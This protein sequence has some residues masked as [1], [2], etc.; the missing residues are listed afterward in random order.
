MRKAAPKDFAQTD[1]PI[2]KD[3]LNVQEYIDVLSNFITSCETPMTLAIQGDWGSGKTSMMNMVEKALP[4]QSCTIVRFNTWQYSQF[5]MGDD[6][7]LALMEHLLHAVSQG[8]D[9]D[10]FSVRNRRAHILAGLR[11]LTLGVAGAA[12]QMA[13]QSVPFGEPLVQVAQQGF[14]ATKKAQREAEQRA[15]P[16]FRGKTAVIEGLKDELQTYVTSALDAL[17]V[18]TGNGDQPPK[19]LVVMIDDLDRLPPERAVEVMEALKIFLDLERCV[20]VLAIDFDVVKQGVRRKFGQ[21]FTERKAIAFF[22]K[23][24]QVPFHMPVA[25]YDIRRFL[26]GAL[27]VGRGKTDDDY[28]TLAKESIGNNPRSLKRLANAFRL[29]S[30]LNDPNEPGGAKSSDIG[31]TM[32]LFA[33]LCMQTSFPLYYQEF[34][35]RVL[36]LL[37]DGANANDDI[38]DYFE[39]EMD[40]FGG[41]EPQSEG[42]GDNALQKEQLEDRRERRLNRHGMTAIEA[43]SFAKFLDRFKQTFSDADDLN[44]EALEKALRRASVTSVGGGSGKNDESTAVK[45]GKEETFRALKAGKAGSQP[46]EMLRKLTDRLEEDCPAGQFDIGVSSTGSRVQYY[47]DPKYHHK[48]TFCEISVGKNVLGIRFGRSLKGQTSKIDVWQQ[49]ASDLGFDVSDRENF[50]QF[51]VVLRRV[52]ELQGEQLD[53]LVKMLVDSHEQTHMH[54]FGRRPIGQFADDQVTVPD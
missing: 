34:V 30:G 47:V 5:E 17:D 21:D 12:A 13:A 4:K 28:V 23:I 43:P 22:D 16:H 42:L 51:Q 25:A 14:E 29:L 24:I 44:V 20:Y 52:G 31:S 10:D 33:T 40:F 54:Y 6:L 48:G 45:Y 38:S 19:R 36:P 18:K 26:L 8:E 39:A 27:G 7:V 15:T 49:C 50:T 35:G 1:A 37:A 41:D 32:Q 53:Q 46:M 2:T 11:A 9:K 3:S